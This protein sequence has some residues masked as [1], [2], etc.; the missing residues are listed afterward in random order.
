MNP[1]EGNI[2]TKL[3][4]TG[5]SI[6][7][8]MSGLANE[9]KA[10]NL[11]QGFPDFPISKELIGL[12]VHFMKKGYN[13]YAPMPGVAPLRMALSKM[14]KENYGASYDADKE[15]TI[16]AGATQ[17]IFTAISAFISKGD[18]AIIFEP[19][20]DCY[21]PSVTVNGGLV[22]YARLQFPDYSINWDE[23]PM[24][25]SSN[26]KMII[27]NSP[28]NPTG[29]VISEDDM[30]RLERLIHGRDII[31]ISDEVYEHLIF[32]GLQH[33]SAARFPELASKTIVVGSFGKTFH[34]TGWKTGFVL[35]PE[36]IMAEF[37]KVHQFVVFAV[38]TPIQYAVAEYLTN[39][40]NYLSLGDFYQQKRD[41]FLSEIS[42]SRFKPLS[43]YGT[44]FQLLDYSSIS[45]VPEMDMAV[46]LVKEF[47]IAAVPVSS[48]YR[49][50]EN[51][52]TLRF[53]FAKQELTLKNAGEILC[54]I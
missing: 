36:K 8:V 54:K 5:T 43:C 24:N 32:D 9:Y 34:T 17:A 7:A 22:K 4:Q 15:I 27:I 13:Q 23:L 42:G 19:A 18:E 44:Y 46:R 28:H 50:H 11:S 6:F 38:N 41:F 47:G 30:I 37:R 33:Q 10:V 14:F 45:D 49:T 25:I 53:C 29:S 31:V 40:N 1:F 2:A 20:Y 3:P 48:F 51:N 35:A 39:P 21:A 52:R 26:T 12:V 16:T